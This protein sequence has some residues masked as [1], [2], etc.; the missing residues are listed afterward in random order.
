MSPR[1]VPP[2]WFW[3]AVASACVGCTSASNPSSRSLPPLP[4]EAG[5]LFRDGA[6]TAVSGRVA[7][8]GTIAIPP[9]FNGQPVLLTVNF[10]QSIPPTGLPVAY[11]DRYEAPAIV[12]GQD[13]PITSSQAELQ[14]T[15]YLT[16]V[17]YCQGGGNGMDPVVG[18]DWV[19]TAMPALTLGPGTGTVEAGRIGLFLEP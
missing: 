7:I 17:L 18:V 6:E 9:E 1:V 2:R 4:V 16:V 13:F 19:G 12:A 3:I 14:G 11:G 8:V 10:F 5:T 15:Y